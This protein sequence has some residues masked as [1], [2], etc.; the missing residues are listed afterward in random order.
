MGQIVFRQMEGSV[1]SNILSNGP[2]NNDQDLQLTY[3]FE[4]NYPNI[5]QGTKEHA[6][7]VEKTGQVS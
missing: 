1:T 7:I 2:E 6:E 4:W 5:E 3:V